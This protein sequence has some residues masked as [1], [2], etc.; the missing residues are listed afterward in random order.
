MKNPVDIDAL[1]SEVVK[2]FGW[3]S[4]STLEELYSQLVNSYIN[5][6]LDD[7]GFWGVR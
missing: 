4:A 1:D 7:D 2:E 3:T 6:V 5:L